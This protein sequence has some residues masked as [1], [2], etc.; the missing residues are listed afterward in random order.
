MKTK[1]ILITVALLC[2][3]GSAFSANSTEPNQKVLTQALKGYLEKQGQFC[4]GKF[5]WPIDVSEAEFNLKTRDAL[6]MPVLEKKGLVVAG[7]ASAMRK[8]GDSEL[9]VP[10]TRY[11]L[12][13]AGKA[14]YLNK[15]AVVY[16]AG[17]QTVHNH[18]LCAGKL[19][20][21]Q[22]VAWDKPVGENQQTTVSYTYKIAAADW[23]HDAEVQKVFPMLA[24]IVNGEGKVKLKQAF[25]LSG[26]VWVP[27][28]PWN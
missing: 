16:A 6:Q 17:K 8:V 12:T 5:D 26:N 24:Q 14:F 3:S 20:L 4:L 21:N 13:D 7:S 2:V 11:T 25:K 18:D 22:V 9:M 27:V 1:K 19:S 10:V 15:E 28:Y 23:T